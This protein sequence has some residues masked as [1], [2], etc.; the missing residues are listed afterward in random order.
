MAWTYSSQLHDSSSALMA[1]RPSWREAAQQRQQAQH[2]QQRPGRAVQHHFQR[3]HSG[4]LPEV[5][6]EQPPQHEGCSGIGDAGIHGPRIVMPVK[7]R[8]RQVLETAA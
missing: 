3:R 2:E 5:Q 6:R 1:N 8:L 7:R 4:D